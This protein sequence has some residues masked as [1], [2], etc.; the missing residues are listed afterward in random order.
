MTETTDNKA[1]VSVSFA[2]IDKVLE[3]NI[4][5]PT[6]TKVK[7]DG[8]DVVLWGKGN[9]YPFYLLDLY[10]SVTTLRSLVNGCVDYA[11]G[12]NVQRAGEGNVVVNR[13]GETIRD[14]ARDAFRDYF[15]CGGFALQVIRDHNGEVS[16]VYYVDLRYL[17]TD[18]ER[19]V[20]YYSED[21]G[22]K[23]ARS[24]NVL[25][26]PKFVP[27]FKGEASSILFVSNERTQTYPAPL[28]AAAI[29]ACEME[30]AIDDFHL[31]SVENGF[32]GSYFVCFHNGVPTDDI[33]EEIE[34]DFVQK[35]TGGKNAG[36]VGFS[37]DDS[38]IN[39]ME[40]KKIDV[41]DFGT[42]Y[43]ALATRARQ[44]IFTAF[45]ANPNLFGIP[46]ENLGFSSEE[47]ESAFR[48]FNRTVIRP[49]Q[50]TLI[51]AFDKI[52]GVT[53]SVVI[54]PFTLD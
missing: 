47:Y 22:K 29:K 26:Y 8:H 34:R 54:D 38:K 3:T 49:A 39:G 50:D 28:F 1:P 13:K 24:S 52:Y 42:K 46:T 2:A 33:K 36:R 40:L 16:E 43:Q 51:D 15:R 4:V 5:P 35:F 6:E 7:Q 25:V 14:I 53:G 44:E 11:A 10:N 9:I 17:R 12:N 20:F 21:Y 19:E 37:Y 32:T 30:R 27:D 45:R 41:E 23:Y 48:L 31:N 18:A